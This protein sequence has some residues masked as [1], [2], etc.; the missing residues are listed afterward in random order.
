VITDF[1]FRPEDLD[2]L[3]AI[4]GSRSLLHVQRGDALREALRNNP[5]VDVVC[6]F[7]P[8][9]ETANLA[10]NLRWIALPSAGAERV[11]AQGLVQPEGPVV[12]T[13]NGV[14]AI[15]I[16]EFVLGLMLQWARNWPELNAL[17][18]EHAWPDHARWERLRGTELHGATL[19]VIGLGAIGRQVARFG[20]V[21]G[22]HVVAARQSA[23]PGATDRDVDVL[24]PSGAIGELLAQSDYV[25][26]A[27]P[28]TPATHHLLGHEQLARMKPT[29]FLVNIARGQIVDEGALTAA[30]TSGRLAG[31]GLDVFEEEPLP[32]E[33]P[34]WGMPNVILSPHIS[35]ATNRYSERFTDLF[36]ENVRRWRA[37]E[38]LLH[39]V[40]PA[41]GY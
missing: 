4:L 18:R 7:R 30:L 36:L 26:I 29:A 8:P 40:D 19:G 13:A 23:Q 39:R 24:L 35:G 3:Q 41:R 38:P 34:L 32:P 2:R 28:S 6:S 16:G 17:R 37:G 25:V 1:A 10:P 5:A 33:S 27:V 20:R 11:V 22:M 14:H 21:L 9:V 15:P 12:T 31:A